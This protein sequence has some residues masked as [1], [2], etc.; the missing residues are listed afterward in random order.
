[1]IVV[2]V[3]CLTAALSG[4]S[5]ETGTITGR[6][7]L[8]SKLGGAALASTAYPTRAVSSARPNVLPEIR[9]VVVYLKDAPY[10]GTLA[11]R[12]ASMNQERETFVPHVLA[13]TR[14]STV[15]FPNVDPIYHNV[16]SLSSVS[17]FNLGRYPTGQSRRQTMTKAGIVKVYCQIHSHMSA[18]ILVFDHPYFAIPELDGSF[19][20]PNLAPGDYTVVGWHERV[21]ERTAGLHV[22]R[23]RTTSIEL[24][25]PVD[26]Q[27]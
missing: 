8:R 9:N 21:G 27:P 10:R 1:M 7:R 19:E 14:G 3:L 15:D 11:P 4:Q 22:E 23:G 18:T 20:I 13:V 17:T 6:V 24:S 26:E 5:Q 12:K 16:F 25:L 2:V